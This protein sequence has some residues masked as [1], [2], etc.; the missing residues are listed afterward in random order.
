[1]KRSLIERLDSVKKC[2]V[3]GKRIGVKGISMYSDKII[4][5]DCKNAEK[6][7]PD[8]DAQCKAW[9]NYVKTTKDEK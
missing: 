8:Y 7:F 1:M 4:C 9:L 3:C 5:E 6:K 2:E